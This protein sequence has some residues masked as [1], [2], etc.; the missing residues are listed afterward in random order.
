MIPFPSL[1]RPTFLRLFVAIELPEFVKESL[2]RLRTPLPGFHWTD[3]DK[4]HLTVKFV[5]EVDAGLLEPIRAALAPLRTEPFVLPVAGVGAFPQ[6]GRPQVV[7]AGVER[8]HPRL[9]A[10]QHR[11]ENALYAIGIE[12]DLRLYHPHLTLARTSQ[13]AEGAVR[14]FVKLHRGY[15]G[16]AF[17]VNGFSLLSSHPSSA[18]HWYRREF[19]WDFRLGELPVRPLAAAGG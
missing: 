16:P 7:W 15:E 13:A 14:H 6:R 18:G 3:D 19:A 10:L 8:G 5:G 17:R 11:V 4:F 1:G 12:P 9:F 2:G